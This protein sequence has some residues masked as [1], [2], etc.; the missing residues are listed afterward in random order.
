MDKKGVC[1]SCGERLACID[2][3]PRETENFAIS[4]SKLAFGREVKADFIQFQV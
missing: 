3:D 2:I 1:G 4:L